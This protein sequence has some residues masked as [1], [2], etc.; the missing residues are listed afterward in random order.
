MHKFF[1]TLLLFTTVN[2]FSQSK[3][4][5]LINIIKSADKILLTSHKDFRQQIRRKPI[6]GEPMYNSKHFRDKLVPVDIYFE[7]LSNNEPNKEIIQ[8]SILLDTVAKNDLLKVI[9]V[10]NPEKYWEGAFCFNPHHTIFIFINQ[11][12]EYVDL[13]F[14]CDNYNFSDGININKKTFLKSYEDWRKLED[15]FRKLNLTYQLPKQKN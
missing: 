6:E 12:W 14:G 2:S 4:D 9:S 1:F 8:E 11:K 3:N 5:S 7:I 15:F 10:Q 13:C